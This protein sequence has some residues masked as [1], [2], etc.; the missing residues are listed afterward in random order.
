M[1]INLYIQQSATVLLNFQCEYAAHAYNQHYLA[2][3]TK[4][5]LLEDISQ[6]SLT[7]IQKTFVH[8]YKRH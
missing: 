4:G 3:H 1:Y 6:K 8:T 7:N 5:P 2:V